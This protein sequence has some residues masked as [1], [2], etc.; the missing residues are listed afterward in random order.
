LIA[1]PAEP[2]NLHQEAK[3]QYS[4]MSHA[5]RINAA[6]KES[7]IYN[8]TSKWERDYKR[9]EKKKRMARSHRLVSEYHAACRIQARYRGNAA[10]KQYQAMLELREKS[11]L[12]IQRMERGRRARTAFA[13]QQRKRE[14]SAVCIQASFRASVHRRNFKQ[15][16]EAAVHIQAR[17]RGANARNFASAKHQRE[18]AAALAIQSRFRGH[19]QHAKY[20]ASREE[21]RRRAAATRI[22]ARVRGGQA[23]REAAQRRAARESAAATHI[24]CHWRGRT[25]REAALRLRTER[26]AAELALCQ[27]TAATNIQRVYR[28]RSGRKIANSLRGEKDEDEPNALGLVVASTLP[29]HDPMLDTETGPKLDQD[30]GRHE[31]SSF[32]GRMALGVSIFSR[33]KTKAR[34][35]APQGARNSEDKRLCTHQRRASSPS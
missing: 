32:F 4:M 35:V 3:V 18:S 6:R 25:G 30:D 2:L 12:E 20:L 24:Q 34:N 1:E 33:G 23:R 27:H 15:Q 31:A 16:R 8:T 9:Y 13:S 5:Q 7:I 22:Q 11:A 28:G 17:V 26:A 19:H 29:P 21:R 10:R 14:E